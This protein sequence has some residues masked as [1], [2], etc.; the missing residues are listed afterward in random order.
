ME[1]GL[2]GTRVS[3][4]SLGTFFSLVALLLVLF[5]VP[6][7]AQTNVNAKINFQPNDATVPSGYT[8]DASAAYDDARGFGWITQESAG[9][10]NP[11]PLNIEP[12]TRDRNANNDQRLDTLTHMQFP[13]AA[14]SSTA[15]KT[16][17]AWEYKLPNGTYD[18]TVAVGDPNVGTDPEEH[19][20]NFEGKNAVDKFVPSGNKGADTRN[21][22]AKITVDV[23]DGK[24]TMDA[25][26]GVNTKPNYVEIVSATTAN[27][28]PSVAGS[29][30]ADG[31]TNVA[32]STGISTTSLNLVNSGV[33]NSTITNNTVKLIKVSDNSVVQSDVNGTGGGD[34]INLQPVNNLQPNTQYRFEISDGVKD[35]DGLA[36]RPYSATFTTGTTDVFNPP[37][38]ATGDVGDAAFDRVAQPNVPSKT[39]TSVEMGPDNRLYA[40]TVEGEIYRFPVDAQSGEL[41]EPTLI[42]TVRGNTNDCNTST[43]GDNGCTN[44]RLIMGITFEPGSTASNPKLWVSHSTY[45]YRNM[46]DW[47]GKL[48]VLSGANLGQYRDVLVNVPRSS[49]DH[50][51]NSIAFHNGKIYIPVGA[52]TAMGAYDDAWKGTE[53]LLSTSIIEVDYNNIS[54][55]LN[56]KTAEGGN[57]DPYALGAPVKIYATG[58]RN[59]VDLVWHS[60][61][62]LYVPTNGS[63]GGS[64]APATTAGFADSE[65][66]KNRADGPYTGPAIPNFDGDNT[67]P[68]NADGKEIDPN[69]GKLQPRMKISK[70]QE[71]YLYRVQKGGYYG[72]PNPI[73]CEWVLNGGNPTAGSNNDPGENPAYPDGTKP[74][75]NWRG[76][77]YN[78]QN[79][80]S[81]NGAIEYKGDNFGGKLKGKLL[82][83]R[84]SNGDDIVVLHP[85]G[86]NGD[87]NQQNIGVPGLAKNSNGQT[88]V[89]PLDLIEETR[90][91]NLYVTEGVK[92]P[93]D[94]TGKITLLR[95]RDSGEPRPAN[96]SLDKSRLITNAVNGTT[97]AQQTVTV[98]NEG[99][100]D[101]NVSGASLSGANAGQFKI[102]SGP[103]G[104]V[105]L[106]PGETQEIGVVFNPTSIG[107]KGA[108][109]DIASNDTDTSV[110]KVNL[111]GLGTKGTGGPN[112]PSLQWILDTY[113]IPVNAGDPD[114]TN[115]AMPTDPS[116]GDE[117]K[118]QRFEAATDSPVTVEPLAVFGPDANNPVVKFGHYAAGDAASKQELFQVSNSPKS[119]AQTLNVPVGEKSFE[120]GSGIFGFYSTWPF[121]NNREVY[122]QDS[123][124]TFNGAIPHHVRTYPLPGEQNAY[125]VATEETTSGFDYQDVVVIVRN[126]KPLAVAS[127]AEIELQNLD[128]V[129]FDDRLAFSRIGSLSSPPSNGVHDTAKVRV[130]NTGTDPLS[131]SDLSINGPWQLVGAPSLPTG[132]A[133]NGQLDLTVKFVAENNG[134]NNG[135]YNGALTIRSDDTDESSTKVEL[136]GFWQSQSENGQEPDIAEITKVYGYGTV[137]KKS[138]ENINNQGRVET[139]GDEIL[140]PYWKRADGSKP[141]GVRQLA[142]YHTQGNTA[143]F[144][145][146]NKG[147]NT[148]TNV[149][150][151]AGI[152]GQSLL[153]RKDGATNV[154]N[155]VPALANF[156]PGSTF[157]FKIDPEWSDPNKN[158][159]S[160]DQ[161]TST[162]PA[163]VEEP[164]CELGHHLRVWP[165]KDRAGD[166]I[167][168]T[169]IA[170]MDYAGINY[171][172]NDNM[173]LIS[174]IRPEKIS[175]PTNVNAVAGDGQVDLKWDA[176]TESDLSGYN[177][178][179]GGSAQVDTSGTP[180]NGSTPLTDPSYTDNNVTNGTTY[181]Y[182]VQSVD[183]G[184]GRAASASI[185]ATPTAPSNNTDFKVNFQSAAAP[186]PSGYF[187]D[188]GQPY[189]AR[190]DADQGNGMVYGWVE[191]GTHNPLDL[192]VGGSSNLGNGRDRNKNSDQ[193]LDTLMHMQVG[194]AVLANPFNGTAKDGSWE[195]SVPEGTY[196]VTVAAGDASVNS[197]PESHTINV[198]GKNAISNFVPSGNA[199][200]D[201][202]HKTATLD[203]VTVSDGRMT[204]DAEGG[205]NSK[206]DYIDVQEAAA[207]TTAP[208]AP[209]NLA[210]TAGDGQVDLTWNA[211]SEDDLKGYNVYRS[212]T[213]Q[214][215]TGGTPLNDPLLTD[216]SYTD[217][218]A[219]NGTTYYYVVT[220]VDNAGN[221]S[222]SSTTASATPDSGPAP[223]TDI[224]VNFQNETVPVPSGYLRDFGQ[225]YGER[226]GADQ[227][228]GQSYGWVEPRTHNPLDLTK[229]GRD[230]NRTGIEQRLD[231]V[232]HMQYG[233]IQPPGSNGN[234][235]PGAWEIAVPDGTYDVTVSVGD[236]PGGSSG[237]SV[238]DSQHTI[239]I[240]GTNAID[241][242]QA[243]AQN[244]Y[245]QATATVDVTDGEL[246]MDA[247]GGTNTKPNYVEIIGNTMVAE[248][249]APTVTQPEDQTNVEGDDVSLQV[250][251]N[252]PDAGDTL[253]YE[254]SGL[255]AGLS[256]AP[257]TG[258]ISGTI[259]SGAAQQ[260]PY[261]VKVTATDDGNPAKNGT[262]TFNWTVTAPQATGCPP[263]STLDCA[264][265]PVALPYNTTFDGTE[266]GLKDTGFTMVDPPSAP[267]TTPSNPDVP[268]YEPGNLTV[269]GG[270]LTIKST[271]GIMYV[272]P[273]KS[274]KTNSQVNALGVGVNA[275]DKTT[276][277]ET[278]TTVP[279]FPSTTNSEQGGLWF[280]LDEDNYAKLVVVNTG[281]GNAKIQLFR[282]IG[283]V[284]NGEAA[285]DE[286]N[287]ANVTKNGDAL[288]LT[289]V[290]DASANQVTAFYTIGIGQEVKLGTLPVPANFFAGTKLNQSSTETASFAGIFDTNRQGTTPINMSFKSFSVAPQ[291]QPQPN[292][293]PVA[294]DDTYN[295]DEDATLTVPAVDGVLSNDTDADAGDTLNATLVD[296]VKSGTLTLNAN[297]SFSYKPNSGFSGKDTFTYKAND[298]T[299]DSNVGTVSITVKAI[300]H[301]PSIEQIEDQSATTGDSFS[302][303]V[304]ASDPDQGD[305]LT[306]DATGL[307]QGLKT[308][309]DTGEISGTIASGAA[310][311][312]PYSVKVTVTDGTDTATQNFQFQVKD[313]ADTTAPATP[314]GFTAT[315]SQSGIALDWADNS[316][317]DLAGYNVSRRVAG[318]DKFTKLNNAL[319]ADSKYD[320]T[321]APAGKTS[322][323]HVTAVDK[324]GNESK[325]AAE[326]AFRPEQPSDT[327]AP[328]T[329]I[330]G[331]PSGFT[332]SRTARFTFKS[333]EEGST[334]E[335]KL[336]G[337]SFESCT[338]PKQY[339]DLKD[340]RHTFQVKATDKAG[341]TDTSAAK[342]T[343][344][345][346]TKGP[347]IHKISPR[348]QTRDRTPTVR[349][350]VKDSQTNLAKSNIKLYFDG[351]RKNNFS[352]NQRTDGLTYNTGK[353]AKK[354]HTV[355]IVAVDEAGNQTVKVWRFRVR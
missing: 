41:G 53:R 56:V 325:F 196:K 174:N 239:N 248:N 189:G 80:Q 172:F 303:Q 283:A 242:F 33:E 147:S 310:T 120:P 235:E 157:G 57:Y 278:N 74:D 228:S 165:A 54:D 338:S 275:S 22:T 40:A 190:S 276:R 47:G 258:V 237:S 229:N 144:Y 135:L 259:E 27:E 265:V 264:K 169:Y 5:A 129:P 38:V 152:D 130:K 51:I 37:G 352:Y 151:H 246:T 185:S 296:D 52:T 69:T 16:P 249:Q 186:V 286:V 308:N 26:G 231:T 314:T 175:A 18:V 346:D 232:I 92:N 68:R 178:Y 83:V 292:K 58:V 173:Y 188:Y 31:A 326:S 145:W 293:A 320:D 219:R 341:N 184:D 329:S 177:V 247:I 6:G 154:S 105:T 297:G 216:A 35:L 62:Q 162:S 141:V 344:N 55:T 64:N 266:G 267:L 302:L 89:D 354:R 305:T 212:E 48:S 214:V 342:R 215:D 84:Y 146:H 136:G 63:A 313:P 97:S 261:M 1:F 140:S 3:K 270:E 36:F 322:Y 59:A 7:Q 291:S 207:D 213:E 134:S 221:V 158:N 317:S 319:L 273:A 66:C 49:K 114:P 10:A 20:I 183:Q 81:P 280:G 285:G 73:R 32:L 260:D 99:G 142:A 290:A 17:A 13:P 127:N 171:D 240:E 133:P 45:G 123:L 203:N 143:S 350:T 208:A 233:D 72:N 282:E 209:A 222:E 82:V 150:K 324:A 115:N 137:I 104:S 334:F 95:A 271:Q 226:T 121:F 139:I 77:A 206:I 60:N 109:L 43:V 238:Y 108:S 85:N 170:A 61:G 256:I 327:T 195:V 12:N 288:K 119:N 311:G 131:I 198:E 351:K 263:R 251:A 253:S 39:Y 182:V 167:A 331:G 223:D 148:T 149:L 343:W 269:A 339:T 67:D 202:R 93:P 128:G 94:N 268:G 90:S 24:L 298:G 321:K 70:T 176:N 255:P 166:P 349:A 197:D 225:P 210:T 75:R 201:T 345:V 96:I 110:A 14:N 241:K 100:S 98:K 42:N 307:P 194:S 113:E 160:K 224:K 234:L 315:A 87:I 76:W 284:S 289:M 191:P 333:S 181:Y 118:A 138:G 11:T 156:T 2:L 332:K 300:N 71:D 205:Q 274:S 163:G 9:G 78:F 25:K 44:K 86:G 236:Q 257:N 279:A 179:R 218:T 309:P 116:L 155:N 107:P 193:R 230:R 295:T 244:E 220:A 243:T 21:K 15:V 112:E 204:I 335:C 330:T 347:A 355:K 316:E 161:C 132:V 153:P 337:G 91:G 111:R 348:N 117:V 294:N 250:K 65:A 23:T 254:A 301:A 336:D 199:G 227:G 272:N 312:S 125:V 281:G 217:N 28:R 353:L 192:S 50:Q 299:D 245:K 277:I 103:T 318:E 287:S 4:I 252:D 328:N 19:T 323:Y 306:Y 211:N 30:P 124:N 106:A 200:S 79:N 168:N 101:L 187:R 180:L 88:M 164:G 262:A 34:A 122:T 46:K 340:G 159:I 29:N 304:K 102:S 8:K 126:V